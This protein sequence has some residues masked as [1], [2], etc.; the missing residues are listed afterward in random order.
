MEVNELAPEALKLPV[1]EKASLATDMDD[2]A[3][4]TL[5]ARRDA[6]MEACE[7]RPLLHADLMAR[8]RR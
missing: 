6:E 8:L 5:S 3:A 1:H 7:V 2:E 4:I